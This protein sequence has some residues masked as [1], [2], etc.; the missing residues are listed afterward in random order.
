MAESLGY[1]L[2]LSPAGRTC[3]QIIRALGGIN[4]MGTV[5]KSPELLKLLD[6][7]AHEDLEVDVEDFD[8]G[9]KK[10]LRKDFAPLPKVMRVLERVNAG[11]IS[12]GA[13]HLGALI[14]SHVLKLGM[15]L[16]CAECLHTSWFSLESLKPRLSCPHCLKKF[17]FPS[18]SP[19]LRDQWA[20]RV[21]GPFTTGGFAGGA[22]CVAA[23]LNFLADKIARNSNWVPSLIMRN[24]AGQQF[25][26][27]FG[28]LMK[29]GW[30]HHTSSPYLFLGECKSF[31]RFEERD[32]ARAKQAA[33]LFPGAILCFCTFNTSLNADEVQG[34]AKIAERGRGRI[35]KKGKKGIDVEKQTN[36][37]LIRTGNELFADL[38]MGDFYSVYGDQA[39]YARAVFMRDDV[40]EL[41]EFTQRIYLG[42]CL[43]HEIFLEEQR[44][45]AAK[46]AAKLQQP[47][48]KQ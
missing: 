42:I 5:T 3:E 9:K 41:C 26:A 24:A 7:L 12:T 21:I 46:L 23:A 19:P 36:P 38:G 31:N 28:I 11:G 16:R 25:E 17:S 29:P 20:Y 6:R 18:G 32:F 44:A 39:D 13:N 48:V 15:A 10:R 33:S 2:E 47:P 1:K 37:V 14:R 35:P 45:K 43:E 4:W 22:Y 8:D 40:N 27:D 30:F 34:L